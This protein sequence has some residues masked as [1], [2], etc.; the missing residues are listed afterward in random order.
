MIFSVS[1]ILLALDKNGAAVVIILLAVV[2]FVTALVLASRPK[3]KRSVLVGVGVALAV[4]IIGGGIAGGVAGQHPTE[5]KKEGAVA[6]VHAAPVLTD[7]EVV[8][9]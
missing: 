1:R 7:N 3:I 8:R 5:E 9:G 4:V 6:A 2:I